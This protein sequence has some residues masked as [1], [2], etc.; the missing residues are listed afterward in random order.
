[1]PELTLAI[2]FPLGSYHA[3]TAAGDPEWPPHP[4]RVAAALLN[5]AHTTGRHIAL[6]ERVYTWS[7]PAVWTPPAA[8]RDI[9]VS[10]WV[11]V[12][13][14]VN[15][16]SKRGNPAGKKSITSKI[17]SPRSEAPP[18]L[19]PPPCGSTTTTPTSHQTTCRP[20]TNYS[21]Q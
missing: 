21:G 9:D 7:A 16:A 3:H 10:R 13:S 2:R 17:P 4:S 8:A 5:A 20:W 11:P 18:S 15:L 1:M 12:D 6:A 19:P 14:P